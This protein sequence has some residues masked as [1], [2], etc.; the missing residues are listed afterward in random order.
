MQPTEEFDQTIQAV[1][2][3]LGEIEHTLGHMLTL[4][5]LSAADLDVDRDALQE[6]M[7]ALK[8]KIDHIANQLPQ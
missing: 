3:A 8:T 1:D 4:A 2:Q 6:V 5:R 7:E